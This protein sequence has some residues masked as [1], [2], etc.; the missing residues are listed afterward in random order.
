MRSFEVLTCDA[1]RGSDCT[2]DDGYKVVFTSAPDAF[3][4]GGYFPKTPQQLLRS[5]P[6]RPSNATHVRLRALTSQCTGGPL[7]AGEQ[8]NDPRTTTDCPASFAGSQ[9]QAAEFEIFSS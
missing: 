3:P 5:F 6:L 2:R 1:T 7:Y 8:D 4:G 9:V